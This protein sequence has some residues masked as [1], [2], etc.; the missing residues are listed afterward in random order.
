MSV[1]KWLI[2]ERYLSWTHD[3]LGLAQ[4]RI[5]EYIRVRDL[6]IQDIMFTRI[7]CFGRMKF[8]LGNFN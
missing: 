5:V 8:G 3:G 7:V 2:L 6:S 1:G 4:K